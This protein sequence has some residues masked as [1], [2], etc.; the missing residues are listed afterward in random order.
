MIVVDIS[1]AAIDA[2][3]T[4]LGDRACEVTWHV[5]DARDL[6]L[7]RQVDIWHDRAVFHFLTEE[8]DRQAYLDS[9]RAALTVGGYVIMATFA[10]EGPDRCSGL[11]VERYD[12]AKLSQ[13]FGPD[14]R[15]VRSLERQHVTPAGALQDY[16]YAVFQRVDRTE[17]AGSGTGRL[18]R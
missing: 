18:S 11:P 1:A 2:A 14:F 16:T 10:P 17:L 9:L 8:A 3:R 12:A 13:F 4:R 6:H 15:L 5:A 7:A